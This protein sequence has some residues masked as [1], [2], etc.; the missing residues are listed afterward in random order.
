MNIFYRICVCV[1]HII[2]MINCLFDHCNALKNQTNLLRKHKAN[3]LYHNIIIG[4]EK[5]NS[6]MKDIFFFFFTMLSKSIFLFPSP[7]YYS[8]TI[9]KI[10]STFFTL[11]S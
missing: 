11:Y 7:R 10:L 6:K 4:S 8:I 1:C 9:H 5:G 3:A 2:V